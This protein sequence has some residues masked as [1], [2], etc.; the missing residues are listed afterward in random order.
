MKRLALVI[1]S[2]SIM[3]TFSPGAISNTLVLDGE[4]IPPLVVQKC[5]GAKNFFVCVRNEMILK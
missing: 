3:S 4:Q 1:F 2:L 5:A